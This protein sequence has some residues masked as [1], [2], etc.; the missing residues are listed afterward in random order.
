MVKAKV[1]TGRKQGLFPLIR[2]RNPWGND[3]EWKGAWSDG[4]LEWK[5]I[6]ED[7]KHRLGLTFEEDGEFYMSQKD[8]LEQFDLLEMCNLGPE[9]LEEDA[10]IRWS[11]A[12]FS[13]S[14][15][16]GRTAGGCRNFIDTFA[17]NPQFRV[18]LVDSDD[19]E[20][21]LCTCVISLM[22]KG[23]R[24]K[25]AMKGDGCLTIGEYH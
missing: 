11:E 19:D 7:E 12:R 25:K 6:P 16:L 17:T 8:F 5:F 4:S 23:S 1:D 20:D 18:V 22:Q 9:A 2:I 21:D 15:V 3:T 14:W 10:N 13:G 24:R